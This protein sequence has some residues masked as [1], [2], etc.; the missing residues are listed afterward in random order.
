M[1]RYILDRSFSLFLRGW[2]AE[3]PLISNLFA[4]RYQLEYLSLHFKSHPRAGA[5][6]ACEPGGEESG[7]NDGRRE[8]RGRGREKG[9]ERGWKSGAHGATCRSCRAAGDRLGKHSGDRCG[10]Y[11][12]LFREKLASLSLKRNTVKS[13][14]LL[15]PREDGSLRERCVVTAILFFTNLPIFRSFSLSTPLYFRVNPWENDLT[16]RIRILKGLASGCFKIFFKASHIYVYRLRLF[17]ILCSQ[18]WF[19]TILYFC[20]V[21]RKRENTNW[22]PRAYIRDI[23]DVLLT[24][25][26]TILVNVI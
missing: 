7:G 5:S 20:F 21:A 12:A 17:D 4:Q 15:H 10:G 22:M 25:R 3:A 16:S 8:K 18:K 1:F 19:P 11:Q 14:V 2:G 6:G 26:R 13:V 9:W 23:F 24:S